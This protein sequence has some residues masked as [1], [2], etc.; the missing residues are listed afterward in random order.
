MVAIAYGKGVILKVP[1]EKMTGD[2]FRN[3]IR[4]HFNITFAQAGPKTDGRRLFVMDNDPSQT[5]RLARDALEEIEAEFHEIP[6]RSPDLNPIENIF[7]LVKRYLESEAI[8]RNITR[9]SF[10]EFQARVLRA[11]DCICTETIDNTIAS[12]NKRIEGILASKGG[13]TKY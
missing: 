3:F 5:S 12:L 6:P 8:S 2:F 9:E 7:H 11:F 13:R 4:E 1:Y 10:E